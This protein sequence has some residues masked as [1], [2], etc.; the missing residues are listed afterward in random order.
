MTTLDFDS[1][2]LV[3]RLQRLSSV[4]S[5]DTQIDCLGM[6]GFD[7]SSDIHVVYSLEDKTSTSNTLKITL[8]SKKTNRPL[9]F[10][11]FGLSMWSMGGSYYYDYGTMPFTKGGSFDYDN[12]VI[13]VYRAEV[14]PGDLVEIVSTLPKSHVQAFSKALDTIKFH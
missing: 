8:L 7:V 11:T 14:V 4:F 3:Y 5:L 13:K 9:R 12:S 1:E 6:I 10:L 2:D